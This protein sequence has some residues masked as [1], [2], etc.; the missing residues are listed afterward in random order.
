MRRL[1]LPPSQAKYIF[2][3]ESC[4]TDSDC[5]MSGQFQ[6][7]VAAPHPQNKT[8]RPPSPKSLETPGLPLCCASLK[9][10]LMGRDL[11][12]QGDPVLTTDAVNHERIELLLPVLP[13][14]RKV[15]DGLDFSMEKVVEQRQRHLLSSPAIGADVEHVCRGDRAAHTHLGIVF[16]PK[17]RPARIIL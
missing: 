9:D 4:G 12:A 10:V 2:P 3:A 15:R 13:L 11:K 1:N 8:D 16:V 6:K 7:T 5:G 17:P 14:A